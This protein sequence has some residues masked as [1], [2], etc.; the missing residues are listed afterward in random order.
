LEKRVAG[1]VEGT[2]D[3]RQHRFQQPADDGWLLTVVYLAA[4]HRSA[5]VVLDARDPSRAPIAIARVDRHFFPGFHGSFTNR[6]AAL[7][8]TKSAFKPV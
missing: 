8:G 2:V 5:L 3:P 4:E 1:Y 6:V 7:A